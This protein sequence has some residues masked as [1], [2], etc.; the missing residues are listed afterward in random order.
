MIGSSKS[1]WNP[2]AK[3]DIAQTR[4]HEVYCGRGVIIC[5]GGSGEEVS[6]ISIGTA[7]STSA[8]S[9]SNVLISIA[10]GI[11]IKNVGVQSRRSMDRLLGALILMF[12]LLRSASLTLPSTLPLRLE[13]AEESTRSPGILET[14]PHC[15]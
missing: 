11:R 2:L 10:K 5:N 14:G 3:Q 9:N 7:S 12:P 4:I 8:N 6:D 1:P 15:I 13:C